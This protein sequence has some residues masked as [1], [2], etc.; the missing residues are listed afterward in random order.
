MENLDARLLQL[1]A[2]GD[3]KRTADKASYDREDQIQRTDVLVIGRI[4]PTRP[5]CRL[6]S[7]VC[8]VSC[9]TCHQSAPVPQ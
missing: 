4:N 6:V 1:G 8:F 7:V 2:H 5:A 9:R 3:R